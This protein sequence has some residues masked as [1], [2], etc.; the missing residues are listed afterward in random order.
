MISTPTNYDEFNNYFDTSSVEDVISKVRADN[1]NVPIVVKSTIPVGFIR[2]M[3]LKYETENI[4]FSL[5]F[6]VRVRR[7]MTICIQ[8]E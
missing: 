5:N 4:F 6:C 8:A 1:T 3:R 7:C 2:K